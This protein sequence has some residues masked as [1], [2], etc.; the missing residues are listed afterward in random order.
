MLLQVHYQTTGPEIWEQTAGKIDVLV[1][2]VGTGGTI[3]GAGRY[4]K[5]QNPNIKVNCEPNLQFNARTSAGRA[6][7][8]TALPEGADPEYRHQAAL[9]LSGDCSW[10]MHCLIALKCRNSAVGCSNSDVQVQRGADA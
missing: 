1:A 3:S 6:V 8:Q 5:E 2:G 7:L 9:G 4:L 10:G